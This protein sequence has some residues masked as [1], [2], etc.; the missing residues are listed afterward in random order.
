M[1]A[2]GLEERLL[3]RR[4]E[5]ESRR[6]ARRDVGRAWRGEHAVHRRPF[7]A[8]GCPVAKQEPMRI[9]ATVAR[10]TAPPLDPRARG[11]ALEECSRRP[12][13][14]P[15]ADDQIALD[16]FSPSRGNRCGTRRSNA[17]PFELAIPGERLSRSSRTERYRTSAVPA[18]DTRCRPCER[19]RLSRARGSNRTRVRVRQRVR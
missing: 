16:D 10:G 5:I 14:V 18:R 3:D 8:A 17:A 7:A 12:K 6:R 4:E 15:G 1:T 19:R 13:P 2:C 11:L 9:E